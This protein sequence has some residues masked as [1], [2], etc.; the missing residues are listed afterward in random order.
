[1]FTVLKVLLLVVVALA[2]FYVVAPARGRTWLEER[3]LLLRILLVYAW[4]LVGGAVRG[5]RDE[6]NK[7]KGE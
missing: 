4:R 7:Q 5:A 3:W 1:M 6:F 2:V